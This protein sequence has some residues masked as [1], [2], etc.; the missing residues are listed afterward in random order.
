MPRVQAMPESGRMTRVLVIEDHQVVAEGLRA[1]IDRESDLE[2]VDVIGTLKQARE[3]SR[4]LAIDVVLADFR[5]PDG[6]GAEAIEAIRKGRRKL[7][8]LFLSAIESP[9]ALMSA[10]QAGARGYVLKSRAADEVVTAVRRVSRGE[11]LIS[12][13]K[14]AELIAIKGEQ[15]H[16]YDTL[17]S[18]EREVLRLMAQG[19]DNHEV[20]HR[21]GIK[22][23]TARSHVRNLLAK[24]EVHNKMQAVVR[25][26]ELGLI[27]SENVQIPQLQ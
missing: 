13:T 15:T 20:A 26:A 17:T 19:L 25:A 10:I 2:V 23:G 11:M 16:L 21:L 12:S 3:L 4:D 5:L 6:N 14:L 7:E 18:R 8:V 24:L 22:Y 27:E 1:L 9:A